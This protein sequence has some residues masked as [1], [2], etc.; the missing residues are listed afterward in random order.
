MSIDIDFDFRDDKT[1]RCRIADG[2]QDSGKEGEFF[3]TIFVGQLWAI[4]LFDG[5]EDPSFLKAKAILVSE[6]TWKTVENLQ[7]AR[8]YD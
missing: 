5:E 6:T 1:S 8:A 3:G 2:W 4:V 7:P